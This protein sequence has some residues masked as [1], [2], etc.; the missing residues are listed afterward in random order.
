MPN[1]SL[2]PYQGSEVKKHPVL[3][4]GRKREF[5]FH[6]QNQE[7]MW[8][9]NTQLGFPPISFWNWSLNVNLHSIPIHSHLFLNLNI[10]LMQYKNL[11]I[12]KGKKD[13]RIFFLRFLDCCTIGYGLPDT[14]R[15]H[16]KVKR[17]WSIQYQIAIGNRNDMC[18]VHH[19]LTVSQRFAYA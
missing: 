19:L 16:K 15:T 7:A 9:H 6:S 17:F 3:S 4:L 18:I 10:L 11:I 14:L 2:L 5:W 13:K 12:C 1:G 8:R